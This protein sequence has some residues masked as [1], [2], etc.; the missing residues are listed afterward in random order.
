GRSST[1]PARCPRY[2]SA[3]GTWR[4]A[5]RPARSSSRSER[6]RLPG[7]HVHQPQPG[8]LQPVDDHLGEPDREL[9]TERRLA[10]ALFPYRRRVE[11]D[12]RSDLTGTGGEVPAVRREQPGPAEHR[13]AAEAV[14]HHA[15]A[16]R[17]LGLQIHPPLAD[18]PEP[19]GPLALL[20]DP[21]TGREAGHPRP[22]RQVV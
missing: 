4:R 14:Q 6:S 3:S 17:Y 8:G 20:E 11:L 19:V 13:A 5:T 9:E 12:R 16:A 7:V 10:L 18:E 2:P 1:G 15:A 22:A 21:G